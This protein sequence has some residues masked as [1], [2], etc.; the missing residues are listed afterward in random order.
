MK[1]LMVLIVAALAALSTLPA[2][3]FK[4]VVKAGSKSLNFT[5]AGLGGFGIGPAGINGGISGS[6]F[7]S[8][9]AALR[10]GLQVVSTSS[11]QP[12]NDLSGNGTNPGSD[13]STSTLGLGL[14]FDYLSYF[15][16]MTPRVKPYVGAGVFV[17]LTSSDTKP[18]IAN[19]AGNGSIT[20][21]KN[22]GASDGLA[23]GLAGMAGAEFFIYP[24]I[25]LSAEYQLNFFSLTSRSDQ[26]VSLK[27]NP[28]RTTKQGSTTQILGF[29]ALGATLHIYF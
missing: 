21:I 8:H 27:G 28:S 11:T 7:A 9:D 2:Q 26:V 23:F 24:E 15:S 4:P 6:Y 3:E 5:F 29:G 12:W 25:S 19:S 13:G 10:I 18:A 1:K 17:K 14:G 20:E 16:S 22:G